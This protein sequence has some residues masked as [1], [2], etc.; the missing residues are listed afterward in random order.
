MRLTEVMTLFND[1]LYQM[2]NN[3][4]NYSLA[5]VKLGKLE[6][7]LE[8][9]GID[10]TQELDK[11]LEVHKFLLEHNYRTMPKEDLDV[12]FDELEKYRMAKGEVQ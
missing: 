2:P 8:K 7:I 5:V 9:Y 12:L 3:K 6:D 4:T 10:D 11:I 1:R